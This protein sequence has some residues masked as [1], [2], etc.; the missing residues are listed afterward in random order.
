MRIVFRCDAGPEIGGGHVMRCLAL[1]RELS[2]RGHDTGLVM[3]ASEVAASLRA[4]GWEVSELPPEA[5]ESDPSPPHAHWLS[6]PWARDGERTVQVLGPADWLVLDHYGLDS[7]WVRVVRQACSGLRVLA[8]DD[9]DDRPL[10]SDLVLDI[11]RMGGR[12]R[13][14]APGQL[15]GPA[16]ALLR[17]EFAEMRQAALARR[18]GP[19]RRA[20]IL[21]GLMDA[22]GLAPRALDALDEAGFEG[23]AEVVMGRG[24]QSRPAVEARVS[25]RGDRILTLDAQ[26]MA[27][28][29]AQADFCIGAGGGTAWERCCQ[30]LPTVAVAV[31]DNQRAQVDVLDRAGAVIGLSLAA[32]CSGSLPEAIRQVTASRETMAAAAASLCDGG[33]TARVA[34]ALEGGLRVLV[35]TDRDL[36]FRWR[37]QPHIRVV[38]HSSAPLDPGTHF[39]WFER[40]RTHDDVVSR[41]YR[42]GGRDLG[43]VAA[44]RNG[45]VW[46][47]SFYLGETN[48]ASGAGG[49]MLGA[50]LR[51][52][53]DGTII[54]G[55]VKT[56]NAASVRL[57]ERLGFERV[58]D[59]DGTL[60]FRMALRHQERDSLGNGNGFARRGQDHRQ[61]G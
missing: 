61:A 49:R 15:I 45:E 46:R 37:D 13:H 35:D 22:A 12:R 28:R 10:G 43:F 39:T 41:I 48:A 42:E 24:A 2:A 3:A 20:L 59:R 19:V 31:A 27:R 4:E 25:G 40:T 47:W 5:H 8:I 17:P 1:A 55:E 32:A 18:S 6:L 9:L 38:S 7:R 34:D 26:D 14:G 44:E 30:G 56:G 57:H 11:G 33:G 52:L 16:F 23:V 29:M 51:L 53:P 54:E 21:P 36:L 60:V 58:A 50:F